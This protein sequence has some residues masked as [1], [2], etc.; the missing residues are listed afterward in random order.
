MSGAVWRKPTASLTGELD[1]TDHT[2]LGIPF[3]DK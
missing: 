3:D 1:L 2:C